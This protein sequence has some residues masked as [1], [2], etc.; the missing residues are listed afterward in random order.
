[1]IRILKSSLNLNAKNSLY[2]FTKKGYSFF[3]PFKA[4]G[5]VVLKINFLR[6]FIQNLFSFLKLYFT[7]TFY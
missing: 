5:M 1:M 6:K 7:K 4:L 3:I 2:R